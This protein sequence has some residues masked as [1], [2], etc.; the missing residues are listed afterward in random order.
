MANF[1][2]LP[3]ELL[4]EIARQVRGRYRNSTLA[5]LSLVSRKFRPIAQ[6]ALIQQP[7]FKITYIDRFML[8]MFRQ[9]YVIPKIQSLE[10]WSTDENRRLKQ[11]LDVV[12]R[13]AAYQ[14]SY[15]A[16]ACP[17]DLMERFNLEGCHEMMKYYSKDKHDER[18]WL[19]ALK[20]DVVPAL[21]ALLLVSLPKLKELRCVALW[22]MDFPIL[23]AMRSVEVVDTHPFE[24]EHNFLAGVMEKVGPRLEVFEVPTNLSYMYFMG[25]PASLFNYTLLVGLKELT[26]SMEVLYY[27]GRLRRP[28]PWP[29]PLLPPNIRTLRISEGSLMTTLLVEDICKVKKAGKS[30]QSLQRVDV[31]YDRPYT[32]VLTAAS[33]KNQL[34]PVYDMKSFCASAELAISL[35]FPGTRIVS[36]EV[37]RSLWS[38]RESREMWQIEWEAYSKRD[39]LCACGCEG[40]S[41]TTW[42]TPERLFAFDADGD[43]EMFDVGGWR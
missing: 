33:L 1:H 31:I 10:L 42:R 22:L 7:C 3:N 35:Y 29:V 6:E 28:S 13:Q 9:N 12:Q 8:E 32:Q 18:K 20:S 40:N 26:V 37:N 36:S 16:V 11:D 14:F 21:L 41:F 38:L 2:D 4:L 17:P 19:A 43:V 15:K 30:L 24:W 39:S 25:R 5:S 27:N 34:D 23:S